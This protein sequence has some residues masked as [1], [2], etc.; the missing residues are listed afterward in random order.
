M[1]KPERAWIIPNDWTEPGEWTGYC[2]QWPNSFQWNLLLKSLLYTLSLG[3]SWDRESGNIRDAQAIGW[4]IFENNH[5]LLVSCADIPECPD[6][7]ATEEPERVF[8]CGG[9]AESEDDEMPCIDL[10]TKVKIENGHLWVKNDCCEWI[11]VG[12]ISTSSPITPTPTPEEF[13]DPDTGTALSE[14]EINC[15]I[16]YGIAQRFYELGLSCMAAPYHSFPWNW[17]KYIKERNSDLELI[18]DEIYQPA[19]LAFAELV[20]NAIT[21]DVGLQMADM[22]LDDVQQL[23]CEFYEV[24]Q[25]YRNEG[26]WFHD[27]MAAAFRQR[28]LAL[29]GNP[30]LRDGFRAA[31]WDALDTGANLL[32]IAG[33]SVNGQ[34]ITCTCPESQQDIFQNPPSGMTWTYHFDFRHGPLHPSVE[35]QSTT[36]FTEGVG[37]WGPCGTTN[38]NNQANVKIRLDAL[39]NGSVVRFIQF[40]WSTPGLSDDYNNSSG[41]FVKVE[42]TEHIGVAAIEGVSG[43]TPGA[44]QWSISKAVNDPLGAA[45]DIFDVS[46]NGYHITG[47]QLDDI[48]ANSFKL[49]G[50]MVSGT[51]P[52]PIANPPD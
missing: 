2:I 9:C 18:D 40:V 4:A 34:D 46:I 36:Q 26:S 16:A 10:S 24:M 29:G 1:R 19:S 28:V 50:L 37:L 38:N 35:L 3:R 17:G 11:D 22:Q 13:I 32:K 51:G 48:A 33:A 14:E 27:D 21:E 49:I 45:E 20:L 30:V 52:G 23:T 8:F 31:V 41:C 25:D 6:C 5:D 43:A 47:T 39:N 44:G 42:D 15:R 12:A 7:P